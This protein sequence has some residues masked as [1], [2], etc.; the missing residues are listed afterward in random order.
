MGCEGI[1]EPYNRRNETACG[2][3]LFK[4]TRLKLLR[5]IWTVIR[6]SFG[7]PGRTWIRYLTFICLCIPNIFPNYNQQDAAFLDLFV[8]TD[9]LHVSGGSFVH[10]REHK[11]LHTASCIV[12]QYC[13]FHDSSKQQYWLTITETVCTVLCSWWCADEP[14]ETCRTSVEINKSTK[15]ASCWL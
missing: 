5:K 9:V 3:S 4:V 13:Y 1:N 8:S 14:P 11:T 2:C 6:D 10:H 15:V 12:S 7:A